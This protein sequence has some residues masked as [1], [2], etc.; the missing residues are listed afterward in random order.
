M[1]EIEPQATQDSNEPA[2]LTS[3]QWDWAERTAEKLEAVPQ[4]AVNALGAQRA[5]FVGIVGTF[6]MIVLA[7]ALVVTPMSKMAFGAPRLHTPETAKHY[8]RGSSLG[9]LGSTKR[10]GYARYLA[11]YVTGYF[12]PYFFSAKLKR[13]DLLMLM[14]RS[15]LF[16]FLLILSIRLIFATED[17]ESGPAESA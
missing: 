15:L 9:K 13:P 10:A 6:A 1:T 16:G 8:V 2:Q 12:V 14:M 11:T 7:S 4:M 17:D 3:M 5:T